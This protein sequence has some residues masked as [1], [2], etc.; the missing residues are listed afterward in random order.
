MNVSMV[1]IMTGQSTGL[2]HSGQLTN[3]VVICQP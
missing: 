3:K 1:I 2:Y